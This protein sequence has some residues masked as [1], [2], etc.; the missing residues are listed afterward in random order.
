MGTPTQPKPPL[1]TRACANC[2]ATAAR[3]QMKALFDATGG[4]WASGALVGKPAS[5]FTSG[6]P[7]GCRSALQCATGLRCALALHSSQTL[8]LIILAATG[9]SACRGPQHDV[10][11]RR[12]CPRLPAPLLLQWPPRAGG[13]RPQS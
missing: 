1:H 5:I 6:A 3:L 8:H 7:A 12:G 2:R 13:R 4:L 11:S 10:H 9:S